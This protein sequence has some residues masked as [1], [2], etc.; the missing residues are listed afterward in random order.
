MITSLIASAIAFISTNIDDL[1]ILM[2]LYAQTTSAA[3]KRRITLGH[4]L[5]I[6]LL[7]LVSLAGAF[8]TRLLPI[9]Y[10]RFLGLIPIFLG[11]R[12]LW[13]LRHSSQEEDT[14]EVYSAKSLNSFSVAAITIANGADN[15]GVYI[16]LFSGF[17]LTALLIAFAVF[18]LMNLLWCRFG[19]KLSELPMIQNLI[20]RWKEPLMG[21]VFIAIGLY[22][23]L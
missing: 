6:G 19:H 1:F 9:Q 2:L 20:S 21:I 18:F 7:T 12:I 16:P 3:D 5:G 10:I 11:V 15:I 23:L 14:T 17:T 22:V 8:G 4:T 13:K